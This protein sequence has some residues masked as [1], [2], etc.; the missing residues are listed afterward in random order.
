VFRAEN[1]GSSR[2]GACAWARRAFAGPKYFNGAVGPG[3]TNVVAAVW[4]KGDGSGA[5]FNLQFESPR[6][7]GKTRQEHYVNLDFTGWRYFEFPFRE[8]DAGRWPDYKWPYRVSWV[9]IFHRTVFRV[10]IEAV[11]LF[12]N[13]IPAGGKAEVEISEVRIV[14]MVE[15]TLPAGEQPFDLV[16]GEFTEL[17]NGAWTKYD[18]DGVPLERKPAAK[19]DDLAIGAPF[20]A[21]S[22]EGV[23]RIRYEAME[24]Q[25]FDPGH[26]FDTLAPVVVRPGERARVQVRVFGATEG[27]SLT[28]GSVTRTAGGDFGVFSGTNPVSARNTDNGRVRIEIVKRYQD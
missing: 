15:R 13:E 8:S 14:P 4:I 5:L 2:R 6:E 27:F 22:D 28:V 20:P 12:L 25:I 1:A 23:R 9:D 24:P 11:G 16:S 3:P 10:K 21:F 17:E 18:K 26:G 19:N 7:Y